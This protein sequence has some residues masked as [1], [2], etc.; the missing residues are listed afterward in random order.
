MAQTTDGSPHGPHT[1]HRQRMEAP[2]PQQD[3]GKERQ[4][5]PHLMVAIEVDRKVRHD[6]GGARANLPP[7][8]PQTRTRLTLH[9]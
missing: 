2:P 1:L 4:Q 8:L 7:F 5:P 9:T 6:Y 3:D